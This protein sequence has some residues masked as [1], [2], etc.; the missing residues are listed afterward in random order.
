M[1]D[2]TPDADHTAYAT[3]LLGLLKH[4]GV[5][6]VPISQQVYKVDHENKKLTLT[7]GP[8][9][10]EAVEVFEKNKILFDAVG[11][12]VVDGRPQLN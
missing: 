7:H 3:N 4:G 2:Y 6:A 10:P 11:Y 8:D 9:T 1:I 5:W 12:R